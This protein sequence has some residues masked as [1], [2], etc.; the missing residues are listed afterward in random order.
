MSRLIDIN[1]DSSVNGFIEEQRNLNTSHKT[2][3]NVNLVMKFL[4]SKNEPKELHEIT[5]LG[6][7]FVCVRKKDNKE[8][9]PTSLRC[10]L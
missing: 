6:E 5:P 4:K 7:F 1:L 8:Y 3:Q 2:A 9:E 10:I